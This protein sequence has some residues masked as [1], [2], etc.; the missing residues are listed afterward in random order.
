MMNHLRRNFSPPVGATSGCWRTIL[1]AAVLAALF[2]QIDSASAEPKSG[3]GSE[4]SPHGMGRTPG[5]LFGRPGSDDKRAGKRP[6]QHDRATDDKHEG[7]PG[8]HEHGQGVAGGPGFAGRPHLMP[9]EAFTKRL[10]ELKLKDAKGTL[11]PEEK[12]ELERMRRFSGP[13]M[14]AEQRKARIAELQQKESGGKLTSEE[15]AELDR[16]KLAQ[17]R[18]QAMEKRA[19]EM[20]QNR[21]QRSRDAKRQAL[22]EFPK[23]SKD[24]VALTEYK[25]HAD[26][27]AKLDRA[28]EL[29]AADDRSDMVQ[30]ID[31][32]I[33]QEKQRH[34]TWLAKQ[35][36]ATANA[37]GAVQ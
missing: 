24:A 25:K 29:A 5:E 10:D 23:L 20:A 4:R 35:P 7:H 22:K 9:P 21:Q 19:A 17:A 11:S 1:G 13:R 18:R 33:A 32:L 31:A 14:T 28:K 15:Q 16:M 12:Q 37:Q 26:R 34:Q 2:L 6:M 30:K 8:H 3:P 36:P 27:L